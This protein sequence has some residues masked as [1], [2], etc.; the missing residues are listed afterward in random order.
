MTV[1]V[2]DVAA[3]S[4]GALTILNQYYDKFSK[5][6][7][8]KYVFV[9]SVVDF[10]PTDNIVI[11]KLPWVKNSWFHR[12]WFDYVYSKKIIKHNKIDEVFSL[13]NTLLP[14]KRIPQTLYLHQSLPFCEYKYTFLENKKFWIYQNIIGK[15]IKKSVK[16]A[17]KVIVQTEWMKQA[18]IKQCDIKQDKIEKIS[19][20]T[21]IKVNKFFDINKWHNLFFYPASNLSYKNHKVIFQAIKLLKQHDIKDFNV[22]FTLTEKTLPHDCIELYNELKENVELVGSIKQEQVMELYSKSILLF[23]SYI[24]TFGLPLLEARCCKSTVIASDTPFSREIL[25]D[26]ENASFFDAFSPETVSEI[27]KNYLVK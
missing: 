8:N 20:E 11:K 16:N 21:T 15:L 2:V 13:Q 23:P 27:M 5:D 12:L 14:I 17:K 25:G 7:D 6:R 18:I 10:E 19:P 9:V 24:E 3:D 22:I 26:Y 4:G 1:L